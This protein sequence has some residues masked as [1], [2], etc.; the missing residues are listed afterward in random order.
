MYE[1]LLNFVG[2]ALTDPEFYIGVVAI[3]ATFLVPYCTADVRRWDLVACPLAH[4]LAAHS[5]P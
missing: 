4:S 1:Q 2:V 5:S 3:F